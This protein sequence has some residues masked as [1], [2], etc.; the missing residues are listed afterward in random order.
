MS[1]RGA[2]QFVQ[3][4]FVTKCQAKSVGDQLEAGIRYLDI[5]LG[6]E[7][8]GLRLMHGFTSCKTGPMPRSAPLDLDALLEQCYAFLTEHPTETVIFAVKQE[9][10]DESVKEFET[11]LATTIDRDADFWLLTDRIPTLGEARG[12]LVLMRRYEDEAGFGA[13]AGIPLLWP[14]QKGH[15]D[16]S[17]NTAMTDNGS[18]DLWVQDRFEYD[19]EDKWNA[20]LGGMRDAEA[21]TEDLEIHFL[22]TKGSASYGHPF[23]F[24]KKLNSRLMAWEPEPGC[25]WIIVDFVSAPLAEQIYS[26]NF[27]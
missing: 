23:A 2:T 16:T 18:Y 9:H 3:L 8:E 17:L 26:V 4:A 5:R 11:A 27:R 12:K 10:G 13:R 14:D 21:G 25:G 22:S 20:F 1:H 15:E 6:V 7:E 19:E 24:A